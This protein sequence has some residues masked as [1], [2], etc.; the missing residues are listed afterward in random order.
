MTTTADPSFSSAV[1]LLGLLERKEVSARELL[2]HCL[3][4][5]EAHDPAINAVVARDVEGARRT[6]AAVDEARARGEVVGPLA[7][8]PLTIKDAFEVVGMTASCGL[9][10]LADHRP[11]RDADAVRRLLDAGAVVY[12]KTNL[13]AGASDWQSYND[14]YGVTRNPWDLERTVGGSSGGSAASIAA[15]FAALELGSDIAGSIRVPSHFCGV[16]GFKPSF[17][18]VSVRGHIPPM[19]GEL[20]TVPLGVAGPIARSASDLELA[21]DVLAGPNELDGT[22]WRLELP[23]SRH[24]RLGDFRVGAWLGDETYRVDGAYRRA[25]EGFVTDVAAAGARVSEVEPPFSSEERHDLFLRTLFAIV[26]GPAPEES[27]AFAA[28]AADDDTGYAER[29]SAALATSLGDWFRLLERREHLFRAFRAF[30]TEV[31]VLICPVAMTVAFPHDTEGRGVHSDQL[32]RRLG[33]SGEAVPYFDNFTWPGLA[34]CAN[35]P[36]T[37]M[38]TGRLVDGLPAGVQIV[39][40]YLED[41]TTL[42]FARLVEAELG[43]FR[44]PSALVDRPGKT[45]SPGEGTA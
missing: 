44:A 5:V 11:D 6:A 23:P 3:E 24:E 38:P 15:G 30:F 16:F 33:V 4:R 35:L 32:F 8:L 25:I 36:A 13:P 43:G 9:P 39:G 20:L 7:G 1:D 27:E 28:L 14:L 37:V 34:T 29:L 45:P 26:G 10:P 12:G 41:R 2:D 31:D 22:G 18:V 19:P 21:L 42:R 40:P 17:G